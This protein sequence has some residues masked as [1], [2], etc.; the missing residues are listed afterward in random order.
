MEEVDNLLIGGL[1]LLGALLLRGVTLHMRLS[2]RA[3]TARLRVVSKREP[4]SLSFTRV[5]VLVL[6]LVLV[7]LLS[8]TIFT[9]VAVALATL[10]DRSH[11]ARGRR[12]RHHG[13]LRCM[14]INNDIIEEGRVDIWTVLSWLKGAAGWIQMATAML[15]MIPKLRSEFEQEGGSV[16]VTHGEEERSRIGNAP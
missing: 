14:R 6:I 2:F 15:L 7:I 16:S 9:A 13:S 12:G 3:H 8:F 4:F 5:R 11:R 1:L 10:I